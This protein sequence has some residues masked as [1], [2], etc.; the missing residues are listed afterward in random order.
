MT[1]CSGAGNG[2]VDVF[3]LNGKFVKRLISGG[4]L[5]SPWG[6]AI[7]PA[8]FGSVGGDLLVGNFGDGTINAFDLNGNFLGSL[9]TPADTLLVNDGLWGLTF[10]NGGNGGSTNALYLTA[11]LNDE[12]DGLF[13]EIDALPAG[14][15]VPEPATLGFRCDR[16]GTDGLEA[17]AFWRVVFSQEDST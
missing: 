16:R 5:N 8:G 7:A 15:S 17:P 11:G 6:L 1:M 12:A 14:S 10:G 3:D 4:P 9:A 13:A 2:S